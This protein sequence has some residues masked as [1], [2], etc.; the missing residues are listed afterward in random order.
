M[1]DENVSD[2]LPK[3]AEERALAQ[4]AISHLL[5][6][7][8]ARWKDYDSGDLERFAPNSL[9]VTVDTSAP[10]LVTVDS[11]ETEDASPALT[12]TVDDVT[13]TVSVSV[14]GGGPFVA[15]VAAGG[16]WQLAAGQITPVL[17]PGTYDV[18]V[19]ATD[20]A[21][22]AVADTT[23]NELT[24]LPTN[25]SPVADPGGPY[26]IVEGGS[27]TLNTAASFDP[28]TDQTMTFTWTV[29]GTVL[30]STTGTTTALTWPDL[31]SLGVDD[32]SATG[33]SYA[34]L[35]QVS[36]NGEPQLSDSASTTLTVSNA[37]P[38]VDVANT[39]VSVLEGQ[40][41]ENS[42]TWSDP[43]ADDVTLAASVGTVTQNDAGTWSW[44]FDT[45]DGPDDSRTVTITATDSDGASTNTTF[46][47]T[48]N[49]VAPSVTSLV[50][51]NAD[52]SQKSDDGDVS[53]SGAFGDPGLDTHAV[54]VSWGD[55]TSVNVSVDQAAN[56][57]SG[58]H[59]YGNGGIFTITVT[60]TDSDG[61]VSASE[62]STA[63]VTGVGLVNGT[64]YI[65]GTD[66][67][68][69]VNIKVNDK[70]DELKV[71][72]KLNQG[73]SDR[74]NEKGKG[75]KKGG[76]DRIKAT[77]TASA[78][79]KIVAIL[80]G[81]D[82]HYNG[83]SDRGSYGGSDIAISQIVLGGGGNDYIKGGRGSDVLIGG[84]GKDK[85]RGGRGDDILI[86][87][88]GKDKLRGGRGDDLLIGGSTDNQDDLSLL[89]A[90]LSAWDSG[91]L[92]DALLALGNDLDDFDKD[93]L[94]GGKGN[95]ELIGGHRDK[96][97]K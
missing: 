77:Y 1:K 94:K 12:G 89:D 69:H 3:T 23:G 81:G 92:A 19:T 53:I 37:S 63:V 56:T 52:V 4:K 83:G 28:D 74:G 66:G 86:G 88:D 79:D 15:D 75:K 91:N 73:G 7:I 21:G 5:T 13:G 72:V 65:I 60:V 55:G 2:R 40:A 51:S 54:T 18:Q 36:D 8:P 33:T 70:K 59:T 39:H 6:T 42:G 43:G 50:S 80:C 29:N 9:T 22:N 10:A 78:I 90:A 30:A 64:L 87:G 68:D 67:R 34:I 93:N 11:L 45:N 47:L 46:D 26:A 49:N 95:D 31:Q 41:A 57:F 76:K 44:R 14:N 32:G 62:T 24:I 61:A 71:D 48:V 38:D 97:K 27:V 17:D 84:D 25:E 20:A 85:L 82:D 35:L 58:E 16:T 96:L